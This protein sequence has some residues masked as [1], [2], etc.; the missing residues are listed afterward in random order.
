MAPTDHDQARIR[1]YLLG[2]LSDEEEEKIEER[3]M[4]EDDLFEELEISKGELIEEYCAGA[5]PQNEHQ[6]FE[7]HYLATPEGRQRQTFTMA[8][9]CLERPIP[10]PVPFLERLISFFNRRRAALTTAAA[11]VIVI[12]I[13]LSIPRSTPQT[14]IPVTLTSTANQR[15]RAETGQPKVSLKP[16]VGE[17]RFYLRLPE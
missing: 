13:A 9:N 5:L 7:R 10:V 15:S 14:F 17:L 6:W 2:R 11:L 16:D 1:Q 4:I 3:L 8:L 12:A